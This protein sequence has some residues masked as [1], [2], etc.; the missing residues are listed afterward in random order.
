MKRN[1][2]CRLHCHSS[3]H[4]HS[5]RFAIGTENISVTTIADG[6]VEGDE[7]IVVN[8]ETSGLNVSPTIVTLTDGDAATL[9][10][11]AQNVSEGGGTAFTVTLSHQVDADVTVAWSDTAD[12]GNDYDP[13][14]GWVTFYARS[15]P[16][17]TQT[18]AVA[19]ADDIL[20]EGTE[21]FSVV[22]GAVTSVLSGRVMADTT[23]VDVTIAESDPITVELSGPSSVNEGETVTYT[24]SLSPTGVIRSADL[25]V[26]YGRAD[27]TAIAG[28]DYIAANGTLT[29]GASET[30][31]DVRVQATE[32]NA[33]VGNDYMDVSG[34]LTFTPGGAVIQEV[35]VQTRQDDVHEPDEDFSLT[36]SNVQGGGGPA[37]SL[38]DPYSVAVAITDNDP[39]PTPEPTPEPTPTLAL[40]LDSETTG[41]SAWVYVLIGMAGQGGSGWRSA[42][43]DMNGEK[44]VRSSAV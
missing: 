21:S 7:T 39:V 36:L 13:D 9:T 32:D 24:V 14:A 31:S 1:A 30:S 6:I 15:A 22:L 34:T 25:I 8:G 17:M 18:F 38:G 12:T 42:G 11:S 35:S 3:H 10:P 40:A 20:S 4:Y 5:G 33:S 43:M 28:S 44:S 16:G 23:T 29:F 19:I 2:G 27:G 41:L 26:H 37:P